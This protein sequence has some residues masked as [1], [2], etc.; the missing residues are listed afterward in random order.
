M[1]PKGGA[2]DKKE[3]VV[4]A[5]TAAL[6][7]G[8][9]AWSDYFDDLGRV[10]AGWSVTVDILLGAL[11]EQRRLDNLPLR[12]F[13]YDRK[14]SQAGDILIEA[15]DLNLAYEVHRIPSPRVVRA[16]TTQ[17]GAEID[18]QIESE[19]GRDSGDPHPSSPRAA[20]G[21]AVLA[22]TETLRHSSWCEWRRTAGDNFRTME[23][24]RPLERLPSASLT[25]ATP[26]DYRSLQLHKYSRRT[27][28]WQILQPKVLAED[29]PRGGAS[30]MFSRSAT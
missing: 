18:L 2:G 12:G 24:A 28:G 7:I 19:E 26:T 27:T 11:G 1:G 30:D 29:G 5:P 15:G 17:S 9:E 13:S 6:E 14:G 16:T 25:R 20:A 22:E 3:K 4:M 21:E 8:K 10:Y 23:H